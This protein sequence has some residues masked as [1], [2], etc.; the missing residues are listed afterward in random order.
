MTQPFYKYINGIRG[1][2]ALPYGAII[3]EAMLES[4]Q[5]TESIR[6]S[7]NGTDEIHFGDYST[8]RMAWKM[9]KPVQ[10]R[11]VTPARGQLSVWEFTE[12]D[13]LHLKTYLS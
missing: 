11:I 9:V 1:Y 5:S 12:E 4:T 6:Q 10:Y 7:L 13:L 3:G 2:Y 8:G